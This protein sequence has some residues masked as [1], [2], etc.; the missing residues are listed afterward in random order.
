MDVGAP[1][2]PDVTREKRVLAIFLLAHYTVMSDL[3]R[4][5]HTCNFLRPRRSDISATI[6]L[7]HGAPK[8]GSWNRSEADRRGD[9]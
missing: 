6:V 2:L 8:Y 5:V 1:R 7:A 3:E 4:Q 9:K